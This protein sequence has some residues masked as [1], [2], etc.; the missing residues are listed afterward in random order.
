M[1]FCKIMHGSVTPAGITKA[2]V[3]QEKEWLK[4]KAD[5]CIPLRSQLQRGLWY[6][7]QMTH[8]FLCL[9]SR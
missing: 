9:C 3:G 8:G 4:F 6:R 2:S 5:A 1:L 7:K